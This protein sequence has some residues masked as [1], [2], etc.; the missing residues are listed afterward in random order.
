MQY[1]GQYVN[2]FDEEFL[3]ESY[4][5]FKKEDEEDLTI[6]QF[7]E[8]IKTQKLKK[9]NIA[10]TIIMYNPYYYPI[11]YD[12]KKSLTSQ[13]FDFDSGFQHLAIEKEIAMF[14]A[15]IKG[16]E[17]QLV[18]I[19]TLFNLNIKKI[20]VPEILVSL[21]DDAEKLN[22]NQYTKF[23]KESNYIDLN[24]FKINGKFV[25]FAWGH[26]INQ[27]EFINIYNYAK[28]IYDKCIQMQKKIAFV[29]RKSTQEEYAREHFHFLHPLDGHK[30]QYRMPDALEKV[31]STH[32][33]LPCAFNDIK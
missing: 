1:F 23:H 21:N 17:G 33:P 28:N 4:L 13:D 24:S 2:E 18:E 12:N 30:L 6:P 7:K 9:K 11:G 26:K 20:D 27:N 19:R 22:T 14:R 25:F 29:F 16:Y 31:F 8:L 5:Y 10:G 32:P 3:T 15:K